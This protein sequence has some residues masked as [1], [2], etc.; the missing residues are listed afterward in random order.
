MIYQILDFCD[1]FAPFLTL[2][3]PKQTLDNNS[4]TC[5]FSCT[6]LADWID[7]I[8]HFVHGLQE[9]RKRHAHLQA[10]EGLALYGEGEGSGGICSP[11]KCWNRGSSESAFPAI[12]GIVLKKFSGYS[13]HLKT[14]APLPWNQAIKS[15]LRATLHSQTIPSLVLFLPRVLPLEELMRGCELVQCN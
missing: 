2:I 5:T 12:Y 9:F 13:R 14:D 15:T 4:N 7:V 11:G 6:G 1:A 3:V 8:L 10:P